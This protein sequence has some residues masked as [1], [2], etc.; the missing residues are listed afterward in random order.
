M[1]AELKALEPIQGHF[2][3][4]RRSVLLW[5][6]C[7]VALIAILTY[8]AW[9]LG[10]PNWYP[11]G[12]RKRAIGELLYLI[13]WWVRGPIFAAL[14]GI[15]ILTSVAYVYHAFDRRPDFIIGPDGI[16]R[17]LLFR[18][19]KLSW[20]DIQSIVLE[21]D[22]VVIRGRAINGPS[23]QIMGIEFS[24]LVFGRT[25]GEVLTLIR[26][27]RPDLVSEELIQSATEEWVPI[28]QIPRA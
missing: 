21:N 4:R 15:G 17:N 6:P 10:D 1:T 16:S 13:P 28:R 27:Y 2:Y 3:F 18:R 14:A 23:L 9:E 20:S 11:T 26:H 24:P 19:F 25:S 7:V 22:R 8:A 5:L 12:R